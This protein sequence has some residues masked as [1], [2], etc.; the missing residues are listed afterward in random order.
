MSFLTVR[1]LFRVITN[2][3]KTDN[4]Y[5]DREVI[6]EARRD[7]FMLVRPSLAFLIQRTTGINRHEF[8]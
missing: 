4:R 7:E 8:H 6:P 5:L 1:I 3:V 2:D